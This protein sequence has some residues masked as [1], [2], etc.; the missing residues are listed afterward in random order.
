MKYA[1]L[2]TEEG[3]QLMLEPETDRERQL[4]REFAVE[5]E[6]HVAG[7]WQTYSEQYEPFGLHIYRDVKGWQLAKRDDACLMFV[8]KPKGK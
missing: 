7:F 4:L 1:V 8:V 5:D 2:L 6:V 3:K